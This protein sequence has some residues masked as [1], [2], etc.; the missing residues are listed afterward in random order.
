MGNRKCCVEVGDTVLVYGASGGTGSFVTQFAKAAGA[1][2]VIAVCSAA[3]HEYVLKL[4]A[5]HAVDYKTED[6]EARVL[7][8]TGGVGVRVAVD[9]VGA[10]SVATCCKVMHYNGVL[11][12]AGTP[13]SGPE[14]LYAALQAA[15]FHG[16]AFS[17]ACVGFGGGHGKPGGPY[18]EMMRCVRLA[19]QLV[20]EERLQVEVS[21]IVRSFE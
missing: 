2:T 4:G 8:I 15:N 6:V 3:K 13:D 1:T 21:N 10:A 20:A 18:E 16:K 12:P 14:E 9:L 19:T 17:V 5:T 7:E 11:C